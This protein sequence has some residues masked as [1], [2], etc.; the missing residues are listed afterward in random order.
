MSRKPETQ[1]EI[2]AF[3]D[4]KKLYQDD[5]IQTNEELKIDPSNNHDWL[6][7]LYGFFLAK[8]LNVE[9]ALDLALYVRYDSDFG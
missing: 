6:S 5:A 1:E 9:S 7:L 3:D 2:Q 4:W 8:G